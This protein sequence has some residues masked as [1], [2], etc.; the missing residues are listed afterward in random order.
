MVKLKSAICLIILTPR[1]INIHVLCHYKRSDLRMRV[2]MYQAARR[3][4][5][6][7]RQRERDESVV[8]KNAVS[9]QHIITSTVGE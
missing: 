6:R 9:C 8:L 4:R 3:E 7:E 1:V 5:E 2:C